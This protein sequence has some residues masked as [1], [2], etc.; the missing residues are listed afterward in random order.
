MQSNA[1]VTG[2]LKRGGVV[3]NVEGSTLEEIY[4]YIAER[5]RLP[6]EVT[7][8]VFAEELLMRERVLSTAVG[9]S[10]AIPHPRR[11]LIKNP[12]NER[13]I[14]CYLK[15]PL[16]MHAPDSFSVHTLFIVLS[17]SAHAHLEVLSSLAKL[18]RSRDFIRFLA[19]KPDSEQLIRKIEALKLL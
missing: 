15:N 7:P 13:I 14:V 16:D 9:N 12:D 1:D 11:T 2:L 5:A 10:L 6:D 17:S 18:F 19:M 3:K 4:G 8:Q